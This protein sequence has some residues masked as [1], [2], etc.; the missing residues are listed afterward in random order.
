M[1]RKDGR[2]KHF[3]K[4]LC[5]VC[6][7]AYT[8]LGG[9]SKYCSQECRKK[10]HESRIERYY[11]EDPDW[12]HKSRLKNTYG[13]SFDEF[14]A[15]YKAQKGKCAICG[16]SEPGPRRR[17]FCIDHNHKTGKVR[18]LLCI[19]CNSAIGLFQDSIKL[20]KKAIAYLEE[21]E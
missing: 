17:H 12:F 1:K 15:M 4:R 14:K 3:E 6:G 11:I 10:A 5:V 18:G 8:P 2:N 7:N 20:L 13:V 21:N 9:T 16:S 19:K